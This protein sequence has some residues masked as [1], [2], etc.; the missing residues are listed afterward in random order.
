MLII[1]WYVGTKLLKLHLNSVALNLN[2]TCSLLVFFFLILICCFSFDHQLILNIGCFLFCFFLFYFWYPTFF[3]VVSEKRRK[4]KIIAKFII[5]SCTVWNWTKEKLVKFIIFLHLY[6]YIYV[7]T[8]G[9]CASN[10]GNVHKF[11]ACFIISNIY[12][13][14]FMYIELMYKY[15][16]CYNDIA[17]SVMIV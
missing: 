7:V 12:D 1:N 15:V 6:I 14:M 13:Y 16:L 8:D 5:M 17:H 3:L 4:T 9:L 11:S 10:A 2:F